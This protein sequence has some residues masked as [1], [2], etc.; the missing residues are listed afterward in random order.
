MR[1]LAAVLL[2]L[3]LFSAAGAR[4]ARPRSQ[5]DS[6]SSFFGGAAG[7]RAT[8]VRQVSRGG[9]RSEARDARGRRSVKS[10]HADIIAHDHEFTRIWI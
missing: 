7:S 6:R 5:L 10:V 4:L 3:S 1:W 2:L 8:S 9:A